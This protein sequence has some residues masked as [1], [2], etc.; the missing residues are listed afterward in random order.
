MIDHGK[1]G[2]EPSAAATMDLPIESIH[3][4]E[5]NSETTDVFPGDLGIFLGLQKAS[6]KNASLGLTRTS[7]LNQSKSSSGKAHSDEFIELHSEQEDDT[8]RA[9]MLNSVKTSSVYQVAASQINARLLEQ[10]KAQITQLQAQQTES[11]R[12]WQQEMS[13]LCEQHTNAL[14]EIKQWY[15]DELAQV[16]TS[17]ESELAAEHQQATDA[18]TANRIAVAT[19]SKQQELIKADYE[20]KLQDALKHRNEDESFGADARRLLVEQHQ[21]DMIH[22]ATWMQ[23]KY[24]QVETELLEALNQMDDMETEL[25]EEQEYWRSKMDRMTQLQR[26]VIAKLEIERDEALAQVE[27]LQVQLKRVSNGLGENECVSIVQT[28][29]TPSTNNIPV[30]EANSGKG[31]FYVGPTTELRI[32]VMIQAPSGA[33]KDNLRSPTSAFG[34]YNPTVLPVYRPTP[35]K[36]AS[37]EAVQAYG[38]NLTAPVQKTPI[39]SSEIGL[40]ARATMSVEDLCFG[41]ENELSY[42]VATAVRSAKE[43]IECSFAKGVSSSSMKATITTPACLGRAE[44]SAF[45]SMRAD[46]PLGKSSNSGDERH[47]PVLL[48]TTPSRLLQPTSSSAAKQVDRSRGSPVKIPSF[49][50]RPSI[51]MAQKSS[52]ARNMDS[53]GL[54]GATSSKTKRVVMLTQPTSTAKLTKPTSRLPTSIGSRSSNILKPSVSSSVKK[55]SASNVAGA[56]RQKSLLANYGQTQSRPVI[57]GLS[58]KA[59]L[60][61]PKSSLPG[62]RTRR[63][64]GIP[65]QA[66]AKSAP[67]AQKHG[68]PTPKTNTNTPKKTSPTEILRSIL[69]CLTPPDSLPPKVIQTPSITVNR[70]MIDETPLD[71]KFESLFSTWTTAKKSKIEQQ[72]PMRSFGQA[73]SLFSDWSTVKKSKRVEPTSLTASKRYKA[74]TNVMTPSRQFDSTSMQPGATPLYVRGEIFDVFSPEELLVSPCFAPS[75]VMKRSL[76][77]HSTDRKAAVYANHTLDKKHAAAIVVQSNV[78]GCIGRSTFCKAK[79]RLTILQ[80]VWRQ[81]TAARRR[82]ATIKAI[83]TVQSHFRKVLAQ[84][85]LNR[86]RFEN[87]GASSLWIQR[88]VR[89]FLAR[90]AFTVLLADQFHTKAV[91]KENAAIEIQRLWRGIL[92]RCRY[93]LLLARVKSRFIAASIL[94]CACRGFLMRRWYAKRMQTLNEARISMECASI[95]IQRAFLDMRSRRTLLQ[96]KK[97]QKDEARL[98]AMLLI[99]RLFRGQCARRRYEAIQSRKKIECNASVVIQYAYMEFRA[100]RAYSILR[101]ELNET[102]RENASIAIQR[103]YR[104]SF[105]RRQLCNQKERDILTKAAQCRSVI[106]I[107]SVIRSFVTRRNLAALK[108]VFAESEKEVRSLAVVKIQRICRGMAAR[109]QFIKHQ[110][111]LAEKIELSR[112]Y[113][114]GEIQ[115]IWRGSLEHQRH[116]KRRA[117]LV[118]AERSVQYQAATNIQRICRGMASRQHHVEHQSSLKEARNAARIIQRKYRISLAREKIKRILEQELQRRQAAIT[119]QRLARGTSDRAKCAKLQKAAIDLE[120]L[121]GTINIQR[122]YRGMV[123]RRL[124]AMLQETQLLALGLARQ[125][126]ATTIQSLARAVAAR[127]LSSKLRAINL[128]AMNSSRS[129]ASVT[130]QAIFRMIMA[131]SNYLSHRHSTIKIQKATRKLLTRRA[132]YMNCAATILQRHLRG[133]HKR[134]IFK[135]TVRCTIVIQ[136]LAR[137]YFAQR[138]VAVQRTGLVAATIIQRHWRCFFQRGLYIKFKVCVVQ[139]Q[140]LHRGI[141]ARREYLHRKRCVIK[142]QLAARGHLIRRDFLVKSFSAVKIQAF[143]RGTVLSR[144][145]QMLLGSTILLQSVIRKLMVHK[146]VQTQLESAVLFQ[147]AWRGHACRQ[148]Q[149]RRYNASIRIQALFRGQKIRAA[150]KLALQPTVT[151][152]VGLPMTSAKKEALTKAMIKPRKPL[153]IIS[154][155]HDSKASTTTNS[156]KPPAVNDSK[157]ILHNSQEHKRVALGDVSSQAFSKLKLHL[158][159]RQVGENC[160]TGFSENNSNCRSTPTQLPVKFGLGVGKEWQDDYM[161]DHESLEALRVVD[162]REILLKNGVEKKEF[163]NVRKAGLIEMVIE[164]TCRVHP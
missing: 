67:V 47:K 16:R 82:R 52:L 160:E 128:L 161:Y 44:N 146:F 6:K 105:I 48:P 93:Q 27:K 142:I 132:S 97:L 103:F 32:P 1:D 66:S 61:R 84:R 23:D 50:V 22:M 75:S 87:A 15:H 122:V 86:I 102:H 49:P 164:R 121:R 91:A 92:G 33:K 144:S 163:R 108:A 43:K 106:V 129:K 57:S 34:F 126:A 64:S 149:M 155:G 96:A 133:T 5:D 118:E 77:L 39:A 46:S 17:R 138:I 19:Y 120:R 100:R 62:S 58:Q 139:L 99:Q 28:P 78:R 40:K 154:L 56:P 38:A 60:V 4:K 59:S 143:Y 140:T 115:R 37:N 95:T 76:S 123:S 63:L 104:G 11:E 134:R 88:V 135:H 20:I 8:M 71:E 65:A 2:S 131:R 156:I 147:A 14:N 51:P 68:V 73:T 117:A 148:A 159:S 114:A 98:N 35:S 21:H 25:Q 13:R 69:D 54:K 109:Q 85:L 141:C 136:S 80:R 116:A 29:H 72:T 30:D 53:K 137:C 162:L 79:Q 70:E 127:L 113:A 81:R 107:Q 41:K 112:H 36:I 74:A 145:Y 152:V 24:D 26:E 150:S 12:H 42:N 31:E 9:T 119:V 45:K 153:G 18:W 94:Q 89:G 124:S 3:S 158:T 10:A 125:H 7:E 101:T 130:I 157:A 151:Q 110:A 55:G 83:V 90:R 111:N